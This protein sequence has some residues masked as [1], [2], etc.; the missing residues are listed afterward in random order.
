VTNV[1]ATT[2]PAETLQSWLAEADFYDAYE[3]PLPLSAAT[4]SPT[5]IFLHASRVTP[6]WIDN[7]MRIRNRVVRLFG[8]KDVGAVGANA[9]PSDGYQV[10]DRIGIFSIFGKTENEL[11]LGIDDSHLDVRV[12]VMKSYR[13]GLPYCVVS[14]GVRVHNLLGHLYMVPCRPHPSLR[15]QINDEAF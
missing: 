7:L 14:T 15:R 11:L 2:V 1:I 10:G 8:L 4:I 13:N 12:S 9:K 3:A 6:Q 5:E